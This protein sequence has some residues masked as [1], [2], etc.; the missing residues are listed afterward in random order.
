MSY[1]ELDSFGYY[2]DDK[3]KHVNVTK[4]RVVGTKMQESTWDAINAFRGSGSDRVN[5]PSHYTRGNQEVIDTIEEAVQDAPTPARGLLQ[6]QVLKYVLRCWLKDNPLE[7]LKKAQ[8]YLT[9]LID[10]MEGDE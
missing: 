7:D 4:P 5:S 10:K 9:R 6:G 8:W 3:I 2:R 1:S